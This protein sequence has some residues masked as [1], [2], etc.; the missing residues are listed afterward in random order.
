MNVS[1]SE[2]HI[3]QVSQSEQHASIMLALHDVYV[4][5]PAARVCKIIVFSAV[6][7][8]LCVYAET[9]VRLSHAHLAPSL[10]S[11]L[12]A[13][14]PHL[15]CVRRP[16]CVRADN[17]LSPFLFASATHLAV[18]KDLAQHDLEGVKSRIFFSQQ[19]RTVGFQTAD[20][21]RALRCVGS[22][23][24]VCAYVCD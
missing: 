16:M 2:Q 23:R 22:A 5:A 20:L 18:G 19:K 21:K 12:I 11:S 3:M 9:G 4:C 8:V 7:C 10:G 13:R 1:Q 14:T 6:L 15:L 24:Q 17:Y